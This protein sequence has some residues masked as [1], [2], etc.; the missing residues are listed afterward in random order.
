MVAARVEQRVIDLLD[1]EADRWSSVD[2]GLLEPLDAV[3]ALVL[4]G[5]KRLRPVFCHWGFV[6]GGGDAEDPRVVDAG[7]AFEMLQAFALIHDDVMDGSSVRRGAPAVHRRFAERHG[8]QRWAGESRR[9]G[10]GVAIL[11]GD[12]ALVYAD[13]L[14]PPGR[15]EVALLWHE[16]RIELNIGQYLDLAGTATGGV[17]RDGAR[18][19]ARLKSGRYTIER[20]LQ[21]G[22]L[23]AGDPALA[24]AISAYGDPLGAAFQQRDDVLGVFGLENRTGKP[25]GDDLREGKPTL[26]L[27]VAHERANERERHLLAQ[28]GQPDLDPQAIADLQA[29]FES[30]GALQVV[31]DEISRLHGTAIDALPGIGLPDPADVALRDL[32]DFVVARDT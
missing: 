15:P 29:L 8:E 3:R 27:A 16:L 30:T 31:E 19:I 7:A 4:A 22:A 12:L 18:R 25:V 17:G 10:E 21:L 14:L 1:L 20:P 13:L 32:A 2:T 28:V 11:A 5:G 6:A 26:L 9:F 24:H 23:L